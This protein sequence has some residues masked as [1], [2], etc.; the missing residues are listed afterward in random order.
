MSHLSP[1]NIG[2]KSVVHGADASATVPFDGVS[3]PYV[4]SM[5]QGDIRPI[6]PV[7]IDSALYLLLYEPHEPQAELEARVIRFRQMA[8]KE[9]YNLERQLAAVQ[10]GR[11]VFSCFF[12]PQPGGTAFFFLA[13]PSQYLAD[14]FSLGISAVRMACRWAFNE[15]GAFLQTLLEIHDAMRYELCVQSGFAHLADLVYMT[16]TDLSDAEPAVLPKGFSWRVYHADDD[17]F[18]A[19]VGETY[20][21][22]M[23]CPELGNYRD[24]SSA[25]Q[26]HRAA[27]RFEGGRW[28]RL[29]MEEDRPVGVLLM[30]PLRSGN[31][32]ELTYMGVCPHGRGRGLGRLLVQE[33]LS[34]SFRSGMD[35]MVLAVDS[36]N[37]L[38]KRIYRE[39]GFYGIA[40]RRVMIRSS[41][42]L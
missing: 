11:L 10:N 16:V 35:S 27:G 25:M 34:L 42:M 20:Q 2:G 37:L 31:V 17:L 22:S 8:R 29:L 19:T 28:W 4:L 9:H 38:A 32:M 1:R 6:K 40:R 39:S 30:A 15:G 7:E 36:Q 12:V 41:T 5:P 13:D 3:G 26:G 24:L 18:Q 23:D 33:A 21:E 14:D